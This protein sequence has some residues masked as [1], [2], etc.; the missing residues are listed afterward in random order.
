MRVCSGRMEL[1]VDSSTWQLEFVGVELDESTK[2]PCLIWLRF[3]FSPQATG[4]SRSS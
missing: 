4:M 2:R 1:L 3:G